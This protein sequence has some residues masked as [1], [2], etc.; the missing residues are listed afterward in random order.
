MEQV[1]LILA[2]VSIIASMYVIL[3]DKNLFSDKRNSIILDTS[4]IIDGR[5]RSIVDSGFVKSKIIVPEY[6]ISELQMLADGSDSLK[7]ERAR[8]GMDTISYLQNHRLIDVIIDRFKFENI[9]EV[10]DK[11]VALAKKSGASLYT[12][13]YNL[14]KVA[15]IEGVKVLNVNELAHSIRPLVLPGEQAQVKIVQKGSNPRQGVGY[16]DDGT[17][18][19][20]DNAA[21][22]L[23][24]TL[25]V[26]FT[27]ILQTDAGKMLFA[28]VVN[29]K[30]K[31]PSS[32]ANSK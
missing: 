23:S 18:V 4:G 21:K 25:N 1:T 20:V 29:G 24:H 26:E 3:K 19:V 11:L 5:I 22:K 30:P 8:Y 2:S 6:V 13:D 32:K 12:T 16:L 27:R 15:N 28:Q 17:M 7:R 10:D 14:N 9:P 31:K